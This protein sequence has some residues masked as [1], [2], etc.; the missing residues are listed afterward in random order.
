MLILHVEDDDAIAYVF[1]KV[2]SGI[3][4]DTAVRRVTNG[5]EALRFLRREGEQ[6][7]APRP[8]IVLLDLDL[9]KINGWQVLAEMSIDQ[10]LQEIPV[11]VL[12]NAPESQ[13]QERAMAMGAK[14][15]LAKSY[16]L[17]RLTGELESICWEYRPPA[18]SVA[19]A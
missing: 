5:D 11:V 13:N 7:A 17:A 16:S 18:V 2:I 19:H 4:F 1:Q 15:Y 10:A 12:S 9:P 14:R 6:D 3:N 8:D